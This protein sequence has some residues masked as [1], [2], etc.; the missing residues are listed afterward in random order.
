MLDNELEPTRPL[1]DD[2][3]ELKA[4]LDA[5]YAP[6]WELPLRGATGD[7][8]K[9]AAKRGETKLGEVDAG[10]MLREAYPGAIYHYIARPYRILR[11]RP[12][13]KEISAASV[14]RGTYT[15]PIAQTRVFPRLPEALFARRHCDA[16]VVFEAQVQVS[17]RVMGYQERVGGGSWTDHAYDSASSYA[18]RPLGRTFNTTGVGWCCPDK[19]GSTAALVLPAQS[20]FR[21]LSRD[22]HFD[23]WCDPRPHEEATDQP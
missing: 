1:P 14:R 22:R 12:R 4:R 19:P 20:S 9:I 13:T 15:R 2:F 6:H 23:P 17:E 11:L 5:A 16:M 8:Y 18:Q 21:V 10:Q 7:R 3:L